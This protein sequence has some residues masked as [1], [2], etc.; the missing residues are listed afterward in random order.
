M[1]AIIGLSVATVI[2]PSPRSSIGS[3]AGAMQ[4][5]NLL[6]WNRRRQVKRANGC[7]RPALKPLSPGAQRAGTPWTSDSFIPKSRKP[8]PLPSLARLAARKTTTRFAGSSGPKRANS[9]AAR[10]KKIRRNSLWPAP[11]WFAWMNWW[12]VANA[13]SDLNL[14][15]RASS[16]LLQ[17]LQRP[18]RPT[19]IPKILGTAKKDGLLPVCFGI[20][21]EEPSRSPLPIFQREE[22]KARQAAT[23]PSSNLRIHLEKRFDRLPQRLLDLLLASFD[24]VHGHAPRAS[25]LQRDACVTDFAQ[26]VRGEQPH[27]VHQRQLRHRVSS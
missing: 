6:Q 26:L 14:R 24:Q 23:G 21:P 1:T 20:F 18:D 11:T 10:E 25:I 15:G 12:L 4:A 5:W 19:S 22:I 17:T 16:S 9:R 8:K 7:D 27:P 3:R 2:I 13:G